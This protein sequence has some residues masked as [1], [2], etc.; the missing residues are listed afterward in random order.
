[1]VFVLITS[2][3]GGVIIQISSGVGGNIH[4]CLGWAVKM[5]WGRMTK[6]SGGEG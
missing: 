1:V 3:E 6:I 4:P 5:Q 2:G